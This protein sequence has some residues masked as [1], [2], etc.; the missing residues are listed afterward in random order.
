[1]RCEPMMKEP[2]DV[3]HKK[4]K[5]ETIKEDIPPTNRKEPT[6]SATLEA[7]SNRVGKSSLCM[8]EFVEGVVLSPLDRCRQT[9]SLSGMPGCWVWT[10]TRRGEQKIDPRRI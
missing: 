5:K 2:P 6:M 3:S 9:R 4:K 7:V 1:M 10:D 8:C